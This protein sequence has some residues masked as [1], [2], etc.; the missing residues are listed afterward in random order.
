MVNMEPAAA[1]NVT[2]STS[3]SM[4]KRW[5]C[6]VEMTSNRIGDAPVL[7]DLLGQIPLEEQIGSV[8]ADGICDTKTCHTATAAPGAEAIIPPRR[9][10]REWKG[11]DPGLWRE[12]RRQVL[13]GGSPGPTGRNGLGITDAVASRPKGDASNCS[14][15]ASKPRECKRSIR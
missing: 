9:N 10:A 2:K 13:A 14:E 15:S 3:A 6:A 5:N 7:P 11:H 12:T 4:L 1:G 8:T